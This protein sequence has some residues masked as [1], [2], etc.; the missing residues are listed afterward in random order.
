[1]FREILDLLL[2]TLND[3]Q[4]ISKMFVENLLEIIKR[5]WK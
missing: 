3:L 2:D 4:M 5:G 1:M